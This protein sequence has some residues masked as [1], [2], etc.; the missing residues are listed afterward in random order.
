M[1][2]DTWLL[3][4]A[5][6][7]LDG[8]VAAARTLGGRVTV[9]AVGPRTLAEAAAAAAPDEVRWVETPDGEPAEAWAAAVG[10]EVGAAAPRVVL[11]PT[12][13]ASRALL[14]AAAVPLGAALVSRVLAL[15]AEDDALV[16][17]RVSLG[18]AVVETLAVSGPLA[19]VLDDSDDAA[20]AAPPA[21]VTAWTPAAAPAAVQVKREPAPGAAA[22]VR[23]A[24]R[25][26]SVGRGL[27]SKDD[28]AVVEPL[29][30]AL[31]AELG[32]SMPVAD[33]LGWV[34]KERYVGRSGQHI[35]PRLYLALGISGMPQH[36]EGVRD[37]KVV[38]A[39]NSDPAAPIFRTADYGVVGDLYEVVP[40][41]VRALGAPPA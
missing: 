10:A 16:V 40:A 1:T 12:D 29:L 13:P 11:S 9:V 23:D 25:V 17:D 39:V 38:A 19:A 14:A 27:R 21:P 6:T 36:M 31:G 5:G 28:L 7:H 18:G 34:P 3:A 2:V 24:A 32:C 8:A 26:V 37:A 30:A 15:R 20:P 41:L 4:A 22:G 33:D 35:A